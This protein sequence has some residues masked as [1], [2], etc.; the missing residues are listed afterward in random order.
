MKAL[1]DV[2]VQQIN[3]LP[4]T[5]TPIGVLT[6]LKG[7]L[8]AK[9][10][11]RQL[12]GPGITT[13]ESGQSTLLQPGASYLLMLHPFELAGTSLANEYVITGVTAGQYREEPPGSGEFGRVV[14]TGPDTLPVALRA[15]NIRRLQRGGGPATGRRSPLCSVGSDHCAEQY[16]AATG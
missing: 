6:N 16:R 14:V 5:R 15:A 1:C 10:V 2:S 9:A 7:V 4:F 8:P 11:V 12:G 13:S 3:D